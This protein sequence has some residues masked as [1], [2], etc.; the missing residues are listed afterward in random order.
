MIEIKAPRRKDR[1]CNV[2]SSKNGVLEL[3]F[4]N[5]SNGTEVAICK[6]CRK[7][8]MEVLKEGADDQI[9]T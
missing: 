6:T 8:L 4:W 1:Q 7:E 9:Q 5:G 3:R 2:C